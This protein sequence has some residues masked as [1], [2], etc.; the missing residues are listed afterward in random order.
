M[1][2]TVTSYNSGTGVMVCDVYNKTGSGTYSSWTVNVGGVSGGSYLQIANNLSDLN[3]AST[4]RTNLGLGTM[5]TEPASSYQTVAGMSAY[6]STASAVAN[7][8]TIAGMSSYLST[9]A[10]STTYIAQSNYATTAQAQ[11][12]SS[13]SA[14]ISASTLLDAKYFSGGKYVTQITWTNATSGVGANAYAQNANSRYVNAPTSATGYGIASAILA[15]IS[16]GSIFNSGFDFSKRIIFGGRF[17][18][19]VVTPDTNSVFR[20]SIGKSSSTDASD[21]SSRGLMVK[22]A[23]SGAMQL[24]VHNGTTLTTTTSSFTPS[25]GQAYDVVVV[26]DGSGNATLYVNGS[27][28]ATS[29]GAAT[30]AGA[31]NAGQLTFETQNTSTLANSAMSVCGSDFFVQVNS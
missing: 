23:G 16:R 29:T 24:L 10:A 3:S 15:N 19:N 31:T 27:S 20:Y 26:S 9:S 30:S 14:V 12:G 22:V 6:L 28:V 18:R 4:A 25:N 5:A 1:H 17:A 8:Q 7:Y 21:L 2:A 13:T 11:A